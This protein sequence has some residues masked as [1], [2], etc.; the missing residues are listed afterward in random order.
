MVPDNLGPGNCL[1]YR[2]SK[3]FELPIHFELLGSNAA[4]LLSPKFFLKAFWSVL[5]GVLSRHHLMV[6]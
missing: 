4:Q 3:G 1:V 2:L 6:V 5:L